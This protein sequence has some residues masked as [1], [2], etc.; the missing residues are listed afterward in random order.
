MSTISAWVVAEPT[1]VELLLHRVRGREQADAGH[2]GRAHGVDDVHE[3]D[4][5]YV[6]DLVHDL[7]H[8][9]RAEHDQLG[10]CRAKRLRLGG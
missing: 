7:V 10:S 9:V 2:R 5:D 8:R 3:R 4:V 6:D 1:Y